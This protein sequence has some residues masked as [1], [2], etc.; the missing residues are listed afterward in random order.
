MDG[1]NNIPCI[2][3]DLRVVK[4]HFLREV[5]TVITGIFFSH[6]TQN[7]RVINWD[8]QCKCRTLFQHIFIMKSINL[9]YIIH[10]HRLKNLQVQ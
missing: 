1:R 3:A 10:T 4:M 8:P 6:V 7:D 2:N 9:F 5:V